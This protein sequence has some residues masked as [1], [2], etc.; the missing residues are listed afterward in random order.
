ME[1]DPF[2]IHV[3]A[4]AA[5]TAGILSFVSPC[6]LPIVP[7]YMC[8]IS[9][10]TAPAAL[11][12]VEPT[13]AEQ[14]ATPISVATPPE[15]KPSEPLPPTQPNRQQVLL[16][17]L[18]FVLG[19]SL[20]FILLGASATSLGQKLKDHQELLRKLGGVA[21]MVMGLHMMG[22]IQIKALLYEKRF[23]FQARPPGY[24]GAFLIGLSFAIGWTP[25]IGPILG[26]ILALASTQESVSNG[27]YLLSL[28]SLGLAIP[29]LVTALLMEKIFVHFKKLQRHMG[30][31]N[32][33][34][35]AFMVVVGILIYS[36]WM[37]N[38]SNYLL[39]V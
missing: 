28:Y 16:S 13:L 6:I 25:C 17:A 39:G 1:L 3:S 11:P 21:V 20:V 30:T 29:F 2:A 32:L 36:N 9:G 24:T 35:G 34:S 27:I 38:L 19:F 23:H 4:W 7:S 22:L 15:I 10:T 33:V 18:L 12:K 8:F 26:S 31:I 5:F 37:Q 14:P